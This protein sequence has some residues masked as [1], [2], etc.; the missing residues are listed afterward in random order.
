VTV[1]QYCHDGIHG[2]STGSE[3]G[4]GGFNGLRVIR[5]AGRAFF[6]ALRWIRG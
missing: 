3:Y 6:R 1:C 2:H 4:L 5:S